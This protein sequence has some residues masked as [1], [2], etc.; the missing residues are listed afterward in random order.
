MQTKCLPNCQ[1]N[2]KVR[3][4]IL[5]L[6]PGEGLRLTWI[7]LW[8]SIYFYRFDDSMWTW[9]YGDFAF[10]D[11]GICSYKHDFLHCPRI[12]KDLN[13]MRWVIE[14]YEFGVLHFQFVNWSNVMTKHAWYRCMERVHYSNRSAQEIN[15]RYGASTDETNIRVVPAPAYWFDYSFFDKEVC[16]TKELWREKEVM[17]WFTEYGLDR[18]IDLDIGYSMAFEE[19]LKANTKKTADHKSQVA[20]MLDT[21]VFKGKNNG[22]F[23]DIGAHDGVQHSNSYFFEKAE[24]GLVCV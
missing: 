14:G 15:N 22:I 8:R 24:I 13:G 2:N 6:K 1:Y 11:D 19:Y 7:Q 16:N 4:H 10:C 18:F 21:F 12:P 23:I 5:N 9:N 3:Q 20:K 17:E